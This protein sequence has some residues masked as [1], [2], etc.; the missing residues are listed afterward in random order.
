MQLDF[1]ELLIGITEI[2]IALAGFCGVVVVFGS[3][4]EGT[5]H[6]GDKLRLGFLIESSLTA[7]GFSLFALLALYSFPEDPSY[8]W[9]TTSIL[10][11]LYMLWSLYSSHTRIRQNLERHDDIDKIMNSLVTGVF[12]VLIVIQI[13]NAFAFREFAPVFAALCS[14][15]AGAAMQFSRLIRSAFHE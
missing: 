1:T 2:A 5:W 4:N 12:V 13:G 6:P 14:N 15:L 7:A 11:A 10:W 8:A 3:R 9:M